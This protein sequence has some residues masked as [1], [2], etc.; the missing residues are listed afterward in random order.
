MRVIPSRDG[1]GRSC[2]RIAR[3]SCEASQL[4]TKWL[5][6]HDYPITPSILRLLRRERFDVLIIAGWSVFACQVA[7]VWARATGTPYLLFSENH[8]RE[9]RPDWIVRLRKLV[10][11]HLIGPASGNLVTGTL[12]ARHVESFGADPERT[13][14]FP[15]TIDVVA[16]TSR[17]SE[18]VQRRDSIRERFGIPAD[19]FVVIQVS[20]LIPVKAIEVTIEAVARAST[21]TDRQ[22]VL[23][24]VGDGP[25]RQALELRARKAGIDA[26]FLGFLE[27]DDLVDAYAV[28]DVSVLLSR[29]ETWGVVINEAMAAGL[30][31]IATDRVGATARSRRRTERTDSSSSRATLREPRARWPTSQTIQTPQARFGQRSRELIQQWDYNA[32]VHESRRRASRGLPRRT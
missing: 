20:R 18:A 25:E 32:G 29:R 24:L 16:L 8:H 30:P 21:M 15:N 3:S 1:R 28:G 19:A 2:T 27:G 26:R 6:Q 17:A 23:V 5:L 12:A 14:V 10:L 22:L 11:P 4:P 31:I 9:P 7:L 13:T